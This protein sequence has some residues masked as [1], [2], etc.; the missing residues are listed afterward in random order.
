MNTPPHP[1]F[2]GLRECDWEDTSSILQASMPIFG[3]FTADS[4]L[5]PALLHNLA[6]DEHLKPMC[7]RYDFLD[8]LVLYDD[9]IAQVRIRLHL[10][11]PGYFDR[12][13]N[14]RWSFAS[15]ILCG[16]Y[17]HR[18]FGRDDLFGEDTDPNSL[19]PIHERI[20]GPGASY[21]LH[22]TSVHTVQA[23]ADTISLLIRGPAAKQRF[24][25]LDHAGGSFWVY[26]AANE[27]PEQRA[28]KQMTA[29]QINQAIS[30]V[31]LL[32]AST[33]GAAWTAV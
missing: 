27:S 24:L 10:Y 2:L 20:E 3:A 14:H 17:R 15:H 12:P 4:Q 21:A 8:K 19:Q 25:I 11:R 1:T 28:G 7:E 32:T 26:G 9:M 22:H 30:R 18:I 29:E 31:Q 6:D 13:H 33:T 5:L 16:R 23:D